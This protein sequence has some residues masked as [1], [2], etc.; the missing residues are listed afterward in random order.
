MFDLRPVTSRNSRILWD[1]FKEMDEFR[2]SFFGE[3]FFGGRET[4]EFRTDISDKGGYYLL[5]SDLPGFDKEDIS[6]EI[7]GDILTVSALRKSEKDEKDENGRYI[8]RER[9]YGSYSRSFDISGVK[10]EDIKAKYEN[11]VLKLELPKKQ[12]TVPESRKL[13]I[14]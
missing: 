12:A 9:S 1:P 4:A 7:N 8:R 6:L 11:G 13:E 5:E 2:R 14:E 10:N 3:P